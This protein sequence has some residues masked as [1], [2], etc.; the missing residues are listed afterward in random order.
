MIL[1]KHKCPNGTYKNIISNGE[2]DMK[3]IYQNRGCDSLCVAYEDRVE[4]HGEI[5]LH[6]IQ[7]SIKILDDAK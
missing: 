3:C 7:R 5:Y 6:C 1:L 2:W 4:T